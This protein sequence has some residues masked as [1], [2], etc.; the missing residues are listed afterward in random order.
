MAN[1]YSNVRIL[2]PFVEIHPHSTCSGAPSHMM[3]CASTLALQ[4]AGCCQVTT[5]TVPPNSSLNRPPSSRRWRLSPSH[6]NSS[7]DATETGN[8]YTHF[9]LTVQVRDPVERALSAYEFSIEVASRE[10][11]RPAN[12]P[13]PS[14]DKINTRNVWPWSLLVP[15][16]EADMQARVRNAICLHILSHSCIFYHEPAI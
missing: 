2:S 15:W 4:T 16:M 9:I 3:S 5:T 1:P 11:R 14:A 7:F 6:C 10:L 12:A 13:R 8:T